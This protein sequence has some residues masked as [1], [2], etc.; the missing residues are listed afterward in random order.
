MTRN[1]FGILTATWFPRASTHNPRWDGWV[2]AESDGLVIP[3]FFHRK[4]FLHHSKETYRLVLTEKG[5]LI[6]SLMR[7]GIP[8]YFS[9]L[10]YI[11]GELLEFGNSWL[12][13][14]SLVWGLGNPFYFFF[15]NILK[16]LK[17][18]RTEGKRISRTLEVTTTGTSVDIR[19]LR[20]RLKI[21]S[22]STRTGSPTVTPSP[23]PSLNP[24]KTLTNQICVT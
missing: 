1:E 9:K 19:T 12:D 20:W 22:Q 4:L 7:L 14:L 6:H 18:K 13:L 10:K 8:S 15:W 24:K 5:V 11:E 23:S 17:K 21:P 2:V 16:E 3:A